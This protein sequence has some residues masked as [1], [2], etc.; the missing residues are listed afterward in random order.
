MHG[1]LN[2]WTEDGSTKFNNI[3]WKPLKHPGLVYVQ[4]RYYTL[5]TKSHIKRGFISIQY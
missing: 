1:W 2:R 3:E 5:L 4:A